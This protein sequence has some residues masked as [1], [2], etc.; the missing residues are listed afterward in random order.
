MDTAKKF[1]DDSESPPS[2]SDSGSEEIPYNKSS[3]RHSKRPHSKQRS[4][5]VK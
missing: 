2:R 1:D 5:D 4:E 3:K